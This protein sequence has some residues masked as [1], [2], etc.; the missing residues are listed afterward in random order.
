MEADSGERRRELRVDGGATVNSGR[1]QFRGGLRHLQAAWH[2]AVARSK[3]GIS[4]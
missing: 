2:L 1:R 4:A 3:S